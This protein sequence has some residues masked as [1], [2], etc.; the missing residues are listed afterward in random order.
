MELRRRFL[1]LVYIVLL[2]Q[3]LGEVASIAVSRTQVA[4]FLLQE[5]RKS[6]VFLL[7]S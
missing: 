6:A 7:G 5:P 2:V 4:I 1:A 3:L